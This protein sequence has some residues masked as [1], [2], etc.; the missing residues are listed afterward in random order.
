MIAR[1]SHRHIDMVQLEAYAAQLVDVP[2]ET[3]V[4]QH[5]LECSDCRAA[6]AAVVAD[7]KI[8]EI[9]PDR[10]GTIWTAVAARI[11]EPPRPAVAHPVRR[12]VRGLWD[13]LRHI[14]S[15]TIPATRP[16]P[17]VRWAAVPIAVLATAV[18][19]M[20]VE[21][22][23]QRS[24]DPS[25]A[26]AGGSETAAPSGGAGPAA[27]LVAVPGQSM[28]AGGVD[29]SAATAVI[30]PGAA[31]VD[32]LAGS[33][34]SILTAGQFRSGA[35]VAA[36]LPAMPD[37]TRVVLANGRLTTPS[38]GGDVAE[39][40]ALAAVE[41]R[42]QRAMDAGVAAAI[43]AIGGGNYVVYSGPY[44]SAQDAQAAC[45]HAPLAG[46]HCDPARPQPSLGP[47]RAGLPK[48]V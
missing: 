37:E 39:P 25:V 43:L 33:R 3:D 32:H 47:P 6:L 23:P 17:W 1:P 36:Y 14:L 38:A 16:F 8:A 21:R 15:F 2:T 35:Y 4:E 20:N 34:P 27:P 9:T 24:A 31:T 28:V 13:A 5:L 7:G 22:T 42:W 26:A 48:A 11:D 10:L 30:V 19:F 29:G 45:D 41:A 44:N 12:L 40:D 46:T 18:V